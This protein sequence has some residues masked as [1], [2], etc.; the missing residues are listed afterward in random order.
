MFAGLK[1]FFRRHSRKITVAEKA[2]TQIEDDLRELY[3]LE[4][5][6]EDALACK[7]LIE[8]RIKRLRNLV[9]KHNEDESTSAA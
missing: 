9:E 2:Q 6:I 1:A 3:A 5:R 4:M 8:K 7:Q